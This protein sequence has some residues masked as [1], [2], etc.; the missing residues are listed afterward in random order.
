MKIKEIKDPTIAKEKF[1]WPWLIE[2]KL[3]HERWIEYI[4]NNQD[5]FTWEENTISGI[6][7]KNNIEKIPIN[8]REKLLISLNKRKAL[9]EFSQKKGWHEIVIS[10]NEKY[11]I[12]STT[13]MKPITKQNLKRL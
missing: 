7:L 13:F 12:I 9:A 3:S 10:Y 1:E 8:F 5:Y 11:G 4:E 6:S 2:N